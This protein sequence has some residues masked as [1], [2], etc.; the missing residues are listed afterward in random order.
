MIKMEVAD[1]NYKVFENKISSN[2]QWEPSVRGAIPNNGRSYSKIDFSPTLRKLTHLKE[3][4]AKEPPAVYANITMPPPATQ[5]GKYANALVAAMKRAEDVKTY[6]SQSSNIGGT[7][8]SHQT[9]P[10]AAQAAPSMAATGEAPAPT[11]QTE[12]VFAGNQHHTVVE[13][14]A[15]HQAP[16]APEVPVAQNFFFSGASQGTKRRKKKQIGSDWKRARLGDGSLPSPTSPPVPTATMPGGFPSPSPNYI[17][18]SLRTETYHGK[19]A[20]MMTPGK[21]ITMDPTEE[22]VSFGRPGSLSYLVPAKIPRGSKRKAEEDAIHGMLHGGK[23]QKTDRLNYHATGKER[24]LSAFVPGAA[25]ILQHPTPNMASAMHADPDFGAQFRQG[26][27]SLNYLVPAKV[28][29]GTKRRGEDLAAPSAKRQKTY[30]AQEMRRIGSGN[31]P[32]DPSMFPGAAANDKTKVNDL[33]IQEVRRLANP[34]ARF[35]IQAEAE[36]AIPPAFPT[37]TGGQGNITAS[38]RRRP[39]AGELGTDERPTKRRKMKR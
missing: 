9:M 22:K 13:E 18:G 14:I 20:S 23:K 3:D 16:T 24:V 6:Q 30:H 12:N 8:I 21:M 19:T 15:A 10:T 36:Y 17:Q 1:I 28:P 38:I 27:H 33:A 25:S 26:A 4:V 35:N 32:Y 2:V 7:N 5:E 34:A 39:R 11:M 29:R 37:F 31:H